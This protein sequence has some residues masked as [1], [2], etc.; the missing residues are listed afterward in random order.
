MFLIKST[1]RLYIGI[2]KD[3][4]LKLNL[5][6]FTNYNTWYMKNQIKKILDRTPK[7]TPCRKEKI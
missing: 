3:A 5:N 2:L 1:F 4:H 6:M 7:L